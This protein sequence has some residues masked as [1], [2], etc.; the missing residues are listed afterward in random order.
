MSA[1]L[2]VQRVLGA[3]LGQ[4]VAELAVQELEEVPHPGQPLPPGRVR[5]EGGDAVPVDAMTWNQLA[6]VES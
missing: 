2:V 4:Q 6:L 5:A 3:P 1:A